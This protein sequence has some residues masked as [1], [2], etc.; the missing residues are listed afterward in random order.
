MAGT[1]ARGGSALNSADHG[2]LLAGRYR[3]RDRCGSQ[4]ESFSWDAV[5]ESLDRPVV[6]LVLP[7]GYRRAGSVL[8]LARRSTLVDDPRL[9]HPLDVGMDQD[10]AYVVLPAVTGTTLTEHVRETGLSSRQARRIVGEAAEALARA[11]EY[12]LHHGMLTPERILL[13]PHGQ[14]RIVGT[15]VD[16]AVTGTT[17]P[18]PVRSRRQDAVDL[19][20]LLY[21]TLTGRWPGP[22]SDSLDL[23]PRSAGHHVAPTELLA[24]IDPDLNA[25][26]TA[27]LD[28]PDAGP[29]SPGDL[30]RLL[31]PWDVDDPSDDVD[32]LSLESRR[33]SAPPSSLGRSPSTGPIHSTGSA[34]TPT[35]GH[36]EPVPTDGTPVPQDAPMTET[37]TDSPPSHDP[38]PSTTAPTPH[39][40][41]AGNGPDHDSDEQHDQARHRRPGIPR[42]RLSPPWSLPSVPAE[43]AG[44]TW[45][46]VSRVGLPADTSEIPAPFL[47]PVSVRRPPEEET[48]FVLRV[49]IGFLV[50]ISLIATITLIVLEPGNST[51]PAEVTTTISST[52]AGQSPSTSATAAASTPSAVSATPDIAGIQAID[53]QGDDS[54]NDARA[55]NAIDRDPKTVWKSSYYA[56]AAFAGLK[57]G[58]GLA[59][60][61][62]DDTPVQQVT[63]DIQGSGG[64][65]E[66]RTA[67]GPGLDGSA[68]VATSTVAD[69]HAVLTP[70]SAVNSRWLILWFTTLPEVSGRYQLVISE[71][72]VR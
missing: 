67:E 15:G 40:P 43:T 14:V 58:V 61:M 6:V 31:S 39:P 59:L 26:C 52:S 62:A 68:V 48:R 11:D 55:Q 19:V 5:D 22:T 34:T 47:A 27:V 16:A 12:G 7:A 71:T 57:K 13:D 2:I 24:G 64:V 20:R 72:G 29:D 42:P 46:D 23:A 69:G 30:A 33:R 38:E 36:D 44:R 18:D 49:V 50:V 10:I 66:L 45:D 17:D 41:S 60:R 32:G 1:S 35:S 8:D 4:E 25:L 3:L 54:E 51:V 53:P 63:I 56:T 70:S 37:T 9:V 28:S 65:V 21:T